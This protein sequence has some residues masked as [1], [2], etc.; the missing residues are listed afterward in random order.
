MTECVDAACVPSVPC[1]R[2]MVVLYA[3]SIVT[4]VLEPYCSDVDAISATAATADTAETPSFNE[5]AEHDTE[6][7]SMLFLIHSRSVSHSIAS[8]SP[9]AH[10]AMLFF[11][12]RS[13][14]VSNKKSKLAHSSLVNVDVDPWLGMQAAGG[15]SSGQNVFG[16]ALMALRAELRE[17]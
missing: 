7:G 1:R 13:S 10:S 17:Q 3:L 16:K 15:I 2:T 4:S 6:V 14:R 8:A 11:S 9:I 12:P 5:S